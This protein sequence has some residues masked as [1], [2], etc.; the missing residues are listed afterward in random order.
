[1]KER[2]PRAGGLQA[3]L[4][5]ALT[6]SRAAALFGLVGVL[7]FAVALLMRANTAPPVPGTAT[8]T[9]TA[10][11]PPVV[12]PSTTAGPPEPSPIVTGGP[13]TTPAPDPTALATR[14]AQNPTAT[15]G[16]PPDPARIVTIEDSLTFDPQDPGT[17]SSSKTAHLSNEGGTDQPLGEPTLEG[18]NPDVF[19]LSFNTCGDTLSADSGCTVDVSFTPPKEGDYAATLSFPDAQGNTL[20][21]VA[22]SGRGQSSTP[23]ISVDSDSLSFDQ[24]GSSGT[25]NV[26]NDG[27]FDANLSI[28]MAGT[29][30]DYFSESDDCSTVSGGGSCSISVTFNPPSDA[31]GGLF[32]GTIDI[33]NAD[34]GTTITTVDLAGTVPNTG[35]IARR[36]VLC[37]RRCSPPHK[38]PR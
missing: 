18:D 38:K 20:A 24:P 3:S 33:N 14:V 25:V 30:S 7:V 15:S 9:A 37:T 13:T 26:S 10:V 22:L 5:R 11:A 8:A 27:H 34:D 31:S 16:P 17:T 12:T 2:P 4:R 29:N 19:S 36:P 1:M 35:N 21:S 28:V 6:S 23:N 32:Y